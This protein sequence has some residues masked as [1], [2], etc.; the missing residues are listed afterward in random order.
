MDF[1]KLLNDLL[2]IVGKTGVDLLSGTFKDLAAD[3]DE[4]WA[5]T[6]LSLLGDAIDQNGMAGVD[7]ARKAI[8]SLFNDEVPDINWASP[9]TASDFVANL[10]NAEADAQSAARDFFVKIGDVFG[11]IF[12]GMIKGLVS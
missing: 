12:T 1:Q 2:P 10:Q 11:Q 9:R 7:L 4:P 3:Q 5:Q 6:A 8:D